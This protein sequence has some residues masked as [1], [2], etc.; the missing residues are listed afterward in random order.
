[1]A[2]VAL[3]HFRGPATRTLHLPRGSLRPP[4]ENWGQSDEHCRVCSADKDYWSDD[5]PLYKVASPRVA[6]SRGPR[7][8]IALCAEHGADPRIHA[9]VRPP[10]RLAA[11]D[12]SV[13][14]T[15]SLPGAQP[16]PVRRHVVAVCTNVWIFDAPAEADREFARLL[17]EERAGPRRKR[18]PYRHNRAVRFDILV[19][20][21]TP[22]GYGSSAERFAQD[23]ADSFIRATFRRSGSELAGC[24]ATLIPEV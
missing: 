20:E 10:R 12:R 23:V 11:E 15:Y 19:P 7:G 17:A 2:A 8:W 9:P 1:M 13:T 14:L 24:G 6:G 22:T 5:R 3:D 4:I 18:A 16:C 21:G